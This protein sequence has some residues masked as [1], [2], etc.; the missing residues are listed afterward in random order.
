MH[1]QNGGSVVSSVADPV[2]LHDQAPEGV[3]G[4]LVVAV[5]VL[6]IYLYM[7]MQWKSDIQ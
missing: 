5:A 1:L 6:T 4:A 2:V 7:V 3:G